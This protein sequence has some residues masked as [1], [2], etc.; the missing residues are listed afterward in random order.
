MIFLFHT[1][2]NEM[3]T[4][5]HLKKMV[6]QLKLEATVAFSLFAVWI[7]HHQLPLIGAI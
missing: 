7:K 2:K 1:D 6:L 3:V 5:N 4:M